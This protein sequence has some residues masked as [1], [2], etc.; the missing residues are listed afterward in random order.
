LNKGRHHS[1][2]FPTPLAFLPALETTPPSCLPDHLEEILWPTVRPE[3][4]LSRLIE[5]CVLRITA[6]STAL[7]PGWYRLALVPLQK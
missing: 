6:G 3:V 7:L 2:L 5:V 4:W 1:L